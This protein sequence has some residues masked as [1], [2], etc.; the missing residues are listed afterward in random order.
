M[1]RW[2]QFRRRLF[3]HLLT[4]EPSCSRL[5]YRT[6]LAWLGPARRGV[7]LFRTSM[8]YADFFLSFSLSVSSIGTQLARGFCWMM[9]QKASDVYILLAVMSIL[10]ILRFIEIFSN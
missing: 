9:E 2:H 7:F 8:Y 1:L 10:R 6:G 3:E 4:S 5:T